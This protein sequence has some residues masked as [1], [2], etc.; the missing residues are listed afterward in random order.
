M[1]ILNGAPERL[2]THNYVLAELVALALVRRF[3]R[4]AVLRFVTDLVETPDIE[5]VWVDKTLY[6]E[7]MKL[8][9]ERQD[10]TYSLAYGIPNKK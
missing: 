6:R 2:L 4:A 3:P 1:Q 7:A 9:A 10:K 5:T 8:L